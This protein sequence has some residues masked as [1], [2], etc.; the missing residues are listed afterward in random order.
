MGRLGG[1]LGRLGGVLPPSWAVL[2]ASW[3]LL[4]RLGGLLGGLG[5]VLGGLGAVLEAS[6]AVLVSSWAVLVPSWAVL[7]PSWAILGLSW[8]VVWPCW[9]RLGTRQ[10]CQVVEG[11]RP[12]GEWMRPLTA[13]RQR[14]RQPGPQRPAVGRPP[15]QFEAHTAPARLARAG[16]EQMVW[17]L[18][19]AVA[20]TPPAPEQASQLT[21]HNQ[22][23]N[24]TR[25]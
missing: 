8:R 25:K 19:Q 6:W 13:E 14:P 18:S 21:S 12:K 10:G 23:S 16:R 20:A 4:G 24:P 2:G 7:G 5:A 17:P 1:L 3:A 11:R 15:K 22:P 9:C